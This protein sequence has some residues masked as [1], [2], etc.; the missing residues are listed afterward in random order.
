MRRTTILFISS[1]FASLLLSCGTEKVIYNSGEYEGIGQGHH[2]PIRVIV[3]TDEY[4]IK[5]IKIIEEYEMPE[6]AK[7]VYEKVPRK[8]IKT[9]SADVDV[10][11]GASYTSIGLIDA[12][13]DGLKKACKVGQ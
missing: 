7:I 4:R 3:T 2:G 6:L 11:A 12:I 10:V 13:K 1:L 5:D 9:N 8:V